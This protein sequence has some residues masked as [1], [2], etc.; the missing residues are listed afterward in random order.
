MKVL[1]I[2]TQLPF[3]PKSGG[4]VKSWNYVK[5]LSEQYKLSVATLLKDEDLNYEKDFLKAL[6]IDQ[7]LSEQVSIK[8]SPINLLKSYI[9]APSLNVFRNASTRFQNKIQA[10]S[11]ECNVLI[12]DHYEV[13]QY[14]PKEFNGKVIMHTH[15]AEFMLWQRMSE[16]SN[17]PIQRLVLKLEA[18]RVKRYE[19][20]IFEN[21]DLVYSTPSDIELYHKHGFNTSKH[22]STFHLGNDTLLELPDL[23]FNETEKAITFIGTLSWEPNIDGIVWFLEHIWPSILTRHSDCKLYILGSSPDDRIKKA[24]KHYSQVIFT[25]FVDKLEDYL[26]KTRVYIA[27]LRFGSG[28]KVKVLEGLY[29]GTPS[30]TTSVGAEGLAIRNEQEVMIADGPEKFAKHCLTL[31][32]DETL[33]AKLRDNSR[34]LAAKKYRWSDLFQQMDLSFKKLMT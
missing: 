21:S 19:K 17:N 1:F 9:S 24:A 4:T 28:M 26:K 13:F 30:V 16:L 29:R 7:Y 20:T 27:P 12:I 8:R 15:N 34:K 3:P 31:L 22:Q 23:E 14:V 2:T 25:G 32:E 33:W 6:S 10:V 5:F 18:N 11:K